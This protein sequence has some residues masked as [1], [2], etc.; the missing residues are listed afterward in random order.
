[1]ASRSEWMN[2][3][4]AVSLPGI[5]RPGLRRCWGS[6]RGDGT[7]FHLTEERVEKFDAELGFVESREVYASRLRENFSTSSTIFFGAAIAAILAA[8]TA[9]ARRGAR[10]SARP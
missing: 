3:P 8:L 6:W 7:L 5:T 1:R 4:P 9:A 2:G 10:A